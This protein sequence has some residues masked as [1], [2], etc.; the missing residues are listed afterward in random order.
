MRAGAGSSTAGS[1]RKAGSSPAPSRAPANC[2]TRAVP[3]WVSSRRPAVTTC[4]SSPSAATASTSRRPSAG[5]ASSSC[6]TPRAH[7]S[8]RF[9]QG[10]SMFVGILLRGRAVSGDR[11]RRSSCAGMGLEERRR[12]VEL[13]GHT[14]NGGPWAFHP[15]DPGLPLSACHAGSARVWTLAAPVLPALR[16]HGQGVEPMIRT[17]AGCSPAGKACPPGSGG[18]TGRRRCSRARY[19]HTSQLP[20]HP[21]RPSPS[22][23]L[24]PFGFGTLITSPRPAAMHV[25]VPAAARADLGQIDDVALSP[26][27]HGSR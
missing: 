4:S 25:R 9:R 12:L 14:V 26:T 23:K 3:R 16:G 8:A 13:H 10:R 20:H 17:P 22:T 7:K 19:G 27:G 11:L 6:G 18:W 2:G 24:G 1:S 21:P 5:A 15:E